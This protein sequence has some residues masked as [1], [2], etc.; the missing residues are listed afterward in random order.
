M[1]R[2]PG[3]YSLIGLLVVCSLGAVYF[4]LQP[5]YRLAE[6]VPDKE[7]AV[8]AS[9]RLDAKLT[10]SNP[11]EVLIEFPEGASLYT[12][13][14]LDTIA[15]VHRDLEEQPGVG[16]VWS[17]ETL[18]FRRSEGGGRLG[19]RAGQGRG[20]AAADRRSIGRE[21]ERGARPPSRLFHRGDRPLGHRRAQ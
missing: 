18:R 7:Q 9:D 13:Q 16:N 2:R 3:A 8:H 5:R 21:A 15:E 12:P 17:L 4:G 11:F 10:G 20:Q 6:Q 1:V 19:L 14:T